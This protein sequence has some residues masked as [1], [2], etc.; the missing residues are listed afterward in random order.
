M[1][2]YFNFW[3]NISKFIIYIIVR[4]STCVCNDLVVYF[5]LYRY[6]N[7]ADPSSEKDGECSREVAESISA[8]KVGM[9][10]K[11]YDS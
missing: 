9:P 4:L 6:K 10:K 5:I 2:V 11:L 3:K 7:V 1:C 8:E